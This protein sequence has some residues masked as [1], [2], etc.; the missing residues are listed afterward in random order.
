MEAILLEELI[1]AHLVKK[2][3]VFQGTRTF[4]TLT[5][6]REPIDILKLS[7]LMKSIVFWHVTLFG[8]AEVELHFDRICSLHLQDRGVTKTS[9]QSEARAT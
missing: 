8:S 1:V 9:S 4:I 7:R 2:S 5:R 3:S 6:S